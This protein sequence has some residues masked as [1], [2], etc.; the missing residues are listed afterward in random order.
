MTDTPTQLSFII[1]ALNEELLIGKCLSAIH[2]VMRSAPNYTAQI[3]VVDNQS[4]DRT[5]EI[6]KRT[7]SYNRI[8]GAWVYR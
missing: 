3:I 2:K 6:A 4:T 7:R 8:Y 1:P 5:A